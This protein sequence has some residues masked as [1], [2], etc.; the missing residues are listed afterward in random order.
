MYIP[1]QYKGSQNVHNYT[2]QG[3][4]KCTKLYNSRGPKIYITIQYK[5]FQ[6]VHNYTIQGVPKCT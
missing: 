6:N 1:I 4:P 2:I 3:V 5:G